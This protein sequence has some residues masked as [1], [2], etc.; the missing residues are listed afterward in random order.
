MGSAADPGSEICVTTTV[1][2][3]GVATTDFAIHVHTQRLHPATTAADR[4][5]P[6]DDTHGHRADEQQHE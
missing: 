2:E 4:L 1:A 6:E 3:F 5:A